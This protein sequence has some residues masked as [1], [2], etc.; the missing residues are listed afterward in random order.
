MMPVFPEFLLYE[1][2]R[3]RHEE[4][5]QESVRERVGRGSAAFPVSLRW[6]LGKILMA[7]GRRLRAKD[8]PLHTSRR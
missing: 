8:L 3:Q 7:L 4:L 2:A 1:L 6:K 5:L